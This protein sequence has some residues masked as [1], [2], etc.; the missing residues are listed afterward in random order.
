MCGIFAIINNNFKISDEHIETAF[1]HGKNRGPDF[2]IL[3]KYNNTLSLGFHR[4]SINGLD[5]NSNQPLIYNNVHLIC[6]GEIYNYKQLYSYLNIQPLSNSDCEII[7][8]L[9]CLYGIEKTLQLLDGVFAFVLIDKRNELNKIFIAR[10]PFGVRPLYS[11]IDEENKI[12]AFASELKCLS[13]IFCSK[14]IQFSPGSYSQIDNFSQYKTNKKYYSISIAPCRYFYSIDIKT[15]LT[16]IQHYFC[17]AV[18]KRYE[19]CMRPVACLLSGGLDSSLV[20]ALANKY[21][22]HKTNQTIETFSIGFP[23][24]DD[25]RN[26]NIVAKHLK[27]KHTEILLD[28]K[29]ILDYITLIIKS[30]E[31]YDVTTIRASLGNYILGEYISQNSDAKVILNG[32]GAD[33]LQGGYLYFNNITNCI[34]FDIECQRLLN[35]IAY[36]DVLRS[37]K[38]ISSHGLEPRTPFLDKSF[39]NYYLSI[40]AEIRFKI[41]QSYGEKY[42]IRKA[43][44]KEQLLPNE[45]LFRR[46]EAFSDGVSKQNKNLFE[47]IKSQIDTAYPGLNE[48]QYY[49]KI[50]DQLYPGQSAVVPYYWMPRYVDAHDPSARLL[51][52]TKS[53]ITNEEINIDDIN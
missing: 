25:L 43:F 11:M 22:L 32:D 37:D 52:D 24:S 21:H 27:T 26:A 30:C 38:C 2:S 33:E 23:D 18:K 28:E 47:I 51:F 36:F 6:N 49:R 35:D 8:H 13:P 14:I 34:D 48:K 17:N 50:F 46:K 9:Y 1:N 45:I 4:L 44:S 3:T 19:N 10:D 40:P 15:I 7:I 29:T 42:L 12:F 53:K 5:S 16:N 39:V 41:H 20:T 31:T